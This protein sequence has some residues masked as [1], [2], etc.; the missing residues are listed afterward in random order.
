MG[1][2]R[3]EYAILVEKPEERR[4]LRILWRIWEDNIKMDIRET[5]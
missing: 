5:G 1:E 4:P 3:N 2:V